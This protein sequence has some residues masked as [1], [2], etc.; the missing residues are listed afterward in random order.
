[1]VRI[2]YFHC[3]GLG[4]VPDLGDWDFASLAVWPKK[5]KSHPNSTI[6]RE[7]VIILCRL[8]Q[9]FFYE[10]IIF[11]IIVIVLYHTGS[12]SGIAKFEPEFDSKLFS[13]GLWYQVGRVTLKEMSL[14]LFCHF[15]S[16]PLYF[17]YKILVE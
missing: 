9:S 12:Y 1:M 11:H 17:C 14:K 4:S 3:C 7:P 6:K 10:R 2:Q 15:R 16:Y 5:K 8:L 13:M